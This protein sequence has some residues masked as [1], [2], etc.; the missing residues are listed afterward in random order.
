M[1]DSLHQLSTDAPPERVRMPRTGSPRRP[2]WTLL[3][4]SPAL[5]ISFLDALVVTTAL[6]FDDSSGPRQRFVVAQNGKNRLLGDQT[7]RQKRRDDQAEARR[8]I[9]PGRPLNCLRRISRKP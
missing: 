2:A 9:S 1:P 3:V 5:M 4:A 8:L 7:R 6:E